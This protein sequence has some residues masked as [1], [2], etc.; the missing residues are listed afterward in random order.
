MHTVV[1]ESGRIFLEAAPR[2]GDPDVV[3]S[4]MAAVATVVQVHDLH[5]WEITSGS[6]HSRHHRRECRRRR[7]QA[8]RVVHPGRVPGA[9]KRISEAAQCAWA[10]AKYWT[11]RPAIGPSI[12][13]MALA[14]ARWAS[15][16]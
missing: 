12:Q 14:G 10:N 8:Q 5:I 13:R 16:G 7:H 2:G 15:P 9:P 3:G 11:V 6:P 1:R 4:Q